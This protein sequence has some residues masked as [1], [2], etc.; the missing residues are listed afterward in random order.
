MQYNKAVRKARTFNSLVP[1]NSKVSYDAR[2]GKDESY[3][4]V[5]QL[6]DGQYVG[7]AAY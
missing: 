2:V 5:I 3:S 4:Y 1:K 6:Y 7:I